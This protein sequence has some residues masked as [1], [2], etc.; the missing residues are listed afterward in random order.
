MEYIYIIYEHYDVRRRSWCRGEKEG[1]IKK[2][3]FREQQ[4]QQQHQSIIIIK[5]SRIARV[6]R[7]HSSCYT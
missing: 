2:K 4:Q 5:R 1:R 7:V 3:G 6:T